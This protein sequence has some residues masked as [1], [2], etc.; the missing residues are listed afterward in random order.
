LPWATEELYKKCIA[1]VFAARNE[2][3]GE[4]T[5][6]PYSAVPWVIS[7]AAGC[8]TVSPDPQLGVTVGRRA[9]GPGGLLV[10]R[11]AG[12]SGAEERAAGKI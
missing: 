12:P 6:N 8:K 5:L 11:P 1:E 2:G 7:V 9:L 4:N 10:A 3:S